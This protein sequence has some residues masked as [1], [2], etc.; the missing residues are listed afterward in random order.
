MKLVSLSS[1]RWSQFLRVLPLLLFLGMLGLNLLA[2][3][4]R[5]WGQWKI[6]RAH[7]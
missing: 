6:G 4:E 1:W 5:S 3:R 2:E 7:V